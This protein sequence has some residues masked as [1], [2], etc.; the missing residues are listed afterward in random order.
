MTPPARKPRV[1]PPP[2]KPVGRLEEFQFLVT[3][4]L[5][6]VEEGKVPRPV[7]T[8]PK[9]LTGLDELRAFIDV[10]PQQL[11]ELNAASR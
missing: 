7:Q 10:F 6:H 1:V 2:A 5:L 11:A 8:D 4:V 9:L 3:P